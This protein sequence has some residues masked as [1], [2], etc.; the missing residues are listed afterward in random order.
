M[1][2]FDTIVIPGAVKFRYNYFLLD[3][4][5]QTKALR[6]MVSFF[7]ENSWSLDCVKRKVD[8][9]SQEFLVRSSWMPF[10]PLEHP[11]DTFKEL[12][13]QTKSPY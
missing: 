2:P 3:L 1:A 4:E 5:V 11:V 7:D 6:H 9:H 13:K 12:K 8:K 10:E